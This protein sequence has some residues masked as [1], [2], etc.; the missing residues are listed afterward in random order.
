MDEAAQAL[1]SKAII[2]LCLA[3]PQTRVVL[4]GDPQQMN[5]EVFSNEAYD[6]NF[7][8]SLLSRLVSVYPDG[9]P[10]RVVLCRNYRSHSAIVDFLSEMFY[11]HQLTA[12]GPQACH[13]KLYP[14]SFVAVCGADVQHSGSTSF[15]NSAEVSHCLKC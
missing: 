5:A 12:C 8:K 6:L 13:A 15:F 10:C 2:P 14:L 3:G 7:H 9:H 11:L 4:A 1:E